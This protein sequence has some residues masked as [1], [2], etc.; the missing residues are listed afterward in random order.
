M[1]LSLLVVDAFEVFFHEHPTLP[2]PHV[3]VEAFLRKEKFAMG[4]VCLV[5][6]QF[7]S[8]YVGDHDGIYLTYLF[9]LLYIVFIVVRDSF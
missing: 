2:I 7:T 4:D 5:F 9:S 6:D 8:M 1:L 3:H